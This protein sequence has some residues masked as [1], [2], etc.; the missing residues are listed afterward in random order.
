M[1]Q[2]IGYLYALDYINDKIIWAKNFKIPFRSNLKIINNKIFLA[3]Q[4]N[5]IYVI[6]KLNGE[7]IKAFQQRSGFK[8]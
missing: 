6:D 2:I 8:K 1:F 5:T 7:K 4:N 3:D